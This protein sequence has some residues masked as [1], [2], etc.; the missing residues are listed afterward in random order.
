[1]KDMLVEDEL[2]EV[3]PVHMHQSRGCSSTC[4]NPAGVLQEQQAT[5]D[6]AQDELRP[7]V[8]RVCDLLF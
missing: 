4:I 8:C 7:Q 5:R 6:R 2:S 1:M 3:A